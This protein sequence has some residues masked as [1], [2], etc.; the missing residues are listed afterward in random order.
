MILVILYRYLYAYRT[1]IATVL[2]MHLQ[3]NYYC[4]GVRSAMTYILFIAYYIIVG[5]PF[6]DIHIHRSRLLHR[7][8]NLCCGNLPYPPACAD[9]SLPLWVTLHTALVEAI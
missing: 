8:A 3:Y 6:F 9:S 7:T 1:L 5:F 4:M 2:A